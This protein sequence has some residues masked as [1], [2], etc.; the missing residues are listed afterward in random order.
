MLVRKAAV[1]DAEAL[2]NI[3]AT[4]A[5]EGSIGPEPPVD[6]QARAQRF[7]ELIAEDAPS[8]TWVLDE[9]GRVLGGA[10]LQ[11]RARGVLNVAMVILPDARGQGGGRRLL[12][13]MVDH[14]RAVGAHKLELEAWI[15][16]ARAISLYASTGFEVE[17]V[18]RNHYRRRDG[19]L[20]SALLMARAV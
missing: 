15:D 12:A 2:A 13:A 8:A 3:I 5:E 17:G 10:W 1:D 19:T 18:R 16:N 9:D 14:A 11:E 20:R 7:R 6:V 4:V